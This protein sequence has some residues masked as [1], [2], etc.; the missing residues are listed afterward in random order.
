MVNNAQYVSHSFTLPGARTHAHALI[1]SP[2]PAGRAMQRPTYPISL[3][4]SPQWGEGGII[5]PW[6][7]HFRVSTRDHNTGTDKVLICSAKETLL[8]AQRSSF[9][10]LWETTQAR[11]ILKHGM[12]VICRNEL[13]LA[14]LPLISVR[15]LTS[16]S[17]PSPISVYFTLQPAC[18]TIPYSVDQACQTCGPLQ[19]HLRPAQRIL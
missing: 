11:K 8:D 14:L 17:A 18:K 2:L 10:W 15:S 5:Q 3:F 9:G 6:R 7:N 12:L 19:A 13:G 4:L 1:H 16:F